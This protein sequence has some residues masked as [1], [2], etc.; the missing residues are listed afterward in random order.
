MADYRYRMVR[1]G[2]YYAWARQTLAQHAN[3]EWLQADVVDIDA[4]TGT[5]QTNQGTFQGRHV[6]N[7]AFLERAVMPQENSVWPASPFSLRPK[8][9]RTPNHA[10]LLQHFKGWYVRTSQPFFD[11]STIT[12]MDFRVPQA[13]ETRFVYVLPFS[14]CEALIEYTAFSPALYKAEAYDEALADYCKTWLQLTDYVVEETEF[15]VIPMT[16]YAFAPQ[17]GGNVH[18]IGTAGGFV[19]ASS[20]YAFTRVQRKIRALVDDWE[21]RGV[22]Q[23]AKAR[24]AWRYRMYDSILLRVLSGDGAMGSPIFSRLFARF[25]ASFVFRFLDEQTSVAE[26]IAVMNSQLS[27]RFIRAAIARLPHARAI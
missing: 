16:D 19:K 2:D 8:S 9:G 23:A 10:Y 26:D 5:V 15:G 25:P 1:G 22:P 6:F 7:S 21:R 13:G 27:W 24:S 20:G 18:N 3:I 17:N 4:A 11:P 14:E 12:L